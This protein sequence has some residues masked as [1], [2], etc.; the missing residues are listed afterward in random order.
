[1]NIMFQGYGRDW[2]RQWNSPEVFARAKAGR[3]IYRTKGGQ[4]Y[5]LSDVIADPIAKRNGLRVW[6]EWRR[7]PP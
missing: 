7:P 6:L 4:E 3:S 2:P 1:M 5:M